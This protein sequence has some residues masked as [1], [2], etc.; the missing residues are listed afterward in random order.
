MPQSGYSLGRDPS[1]LG[2]VNW[3]LRSTEWSHPS[4]LYI[5]DFL[6]GHPDAKILEIG[7][8]WGLM[9]FVIARL[10]PK[11][12]IDWLLYGNKGKEFVGTY[13]AGLSKVRDYS[14]SINTIT[15][16]IIELD[17]SVVEENM[18]DLVVMTEVFE[19]FVLNPVDTMSIIRKSLKNG[20]RMV[21]TTPNWGHLT[22]YNSWKN[23]PTKLEINDERYMD[24]KECG[25]VYQYSKEELMEIFKEANWN[26]EKYD[27][28]ESNNHNFLIYK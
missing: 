8:G 17:Y 14:K 21:L 1:K 4:Y 12:E 3:L 15:Y 16:G 19:H 20:G 28:S 23:L 27:I 25:H 13:E 5:Y 18:Y 11:V 22:T 10:F 2:N 6:K 9:S 26:I 24:L 7:P